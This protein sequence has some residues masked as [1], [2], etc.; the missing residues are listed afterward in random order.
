[1]QLVGEVRSAWQRAQQNRRSCDGSRFASPSPNS[2]RTQQT[3]QV[4]LRRTHSEHGLEALSIKRGQTSSMRL[5]SKFLS[6]L[7]QRIGCFS[8]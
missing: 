3:V 2:N 7:M 5:C 4:G 8:R 1:M 6:R